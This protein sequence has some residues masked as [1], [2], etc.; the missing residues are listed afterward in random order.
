MPD[1]KIDSNDGQIIHFNLDTLEISSVRGRVR[2]ESKGVSEIL[3][4][5]KMAE[6]EDTDDPEGTYCTQTGFKSY[7]SPEIPISS[8]VK[9]ALACREIVRP[10][11][12][13]DK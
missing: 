7:K 11:S 13:H 2:G 1:D 9:E 5:V 6:I 8:T 10:K 12:F 4:A 3:K